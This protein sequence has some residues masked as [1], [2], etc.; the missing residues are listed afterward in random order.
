MVGGEKR[1]PLPPDRSEDSE[2]DFDERGGRTGRPARSAA[3][4]PRPR[5]PAPEGGRQKAARGTDAPCEKGRDAK[6][7]R[8]IIRL[9]AWSTFTA[10][11]VHLRPYSADAEALVL[12]LDLNAPRMVAWRL[13]WV[14]LVDL[15]GEHDANFFLQLMSYPEHLPNLARLRPPGGNASGWGGTR[16]TSRGGLAGNCPPSTTAGF[17]ARCNS[18]K[19]YSTE[20]GT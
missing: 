15:A 4:I 18:P 3:S 5:R 7:Q 13:L 20:G 1:P 9:R 17:S 8:L 14:R 16:A 10:R 19:A 11:W 12:K 2:H 6:W